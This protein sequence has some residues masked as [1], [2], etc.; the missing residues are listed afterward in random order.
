MKK[1]RN[2]SQLEN[3]TEDNHSNKNSQVEEQYRSTSTE[4]YDYESGDFGHK[5]HFTQKNP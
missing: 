5:R 2:I 3:H 4:G 1:K